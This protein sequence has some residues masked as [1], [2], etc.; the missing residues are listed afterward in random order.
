MG[1]MATGGI[2]DLHK[3]PT[4]NRFFLPKHRRHLLSDK[5]VG[6]ATFSW[7]LPGLAQVQEELIECFK[8][9]GPSGTL[10]T[11]GFSRYKLFILDLI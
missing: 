4:E 7:F 1:V 8:K 5:G 3:A 6:M 9:D 2:V 10:I 11:V